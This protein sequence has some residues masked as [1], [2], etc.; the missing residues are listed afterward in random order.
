MLWL[1]STHAAN[2]AKQVTELMFSAGGSP[3]PYVSNGLERC[4][5]DI[6]ASGQHMALRRPVKHGR[7]GALG[8]G[9][10]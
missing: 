6:Y 9:H 3:L 5:R 1:A 10:A 8:L 4:V 2:A 7:S